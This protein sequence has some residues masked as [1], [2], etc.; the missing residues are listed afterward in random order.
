MAIADAIRALGDAAG[1]DAFACMYER[2][3]RRERFTRLLEADDGWIAVS[4]ARPDDVVAIPAWLEIDAAVD[5]DPWPVVERAVRTRSGVS[6]VERARLL[7]IAAAVLGER[8]PPPPWRG[9][10]VVA[11]SLG[12]APALIRPPRIVNLSSLWA[13]PLCARILAS[14]GATVEAPWPVSAAALLHADVVIEGSRPRALEQLGIDAAAIARRGPQV[15]LSITGHGRAEPECNWIGFGDD[16]AVSGGLVEWRGE[17]P[18]LFA[19]AAADPLTG[20]T[21][22]AAVTSALA[23]GGRWL[24]DCNLSG[25]AAH[26]AAAA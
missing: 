21:A 24:I 10:P 12:D 6:V 1:V 8:M 16:A 18:V 13:G 2:G 26:V 22:A 23:S 14:R 15:W 19:D 3:E 11:T 5:G 17:R 20:M 25:V 4:L 7:G 9:L